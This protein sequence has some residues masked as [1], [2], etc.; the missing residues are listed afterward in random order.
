LIRFIHFLLI[1]SILSPADINC[2]QAKII[3]KHRVKKGIALQEYPGS[4]D[5][6][7]KNSLFKVNVTHL[8]GG[9]NAILRKTLL[10]FNYGTSF[11]LFLIALQDVTKLC[12]IPPLDLGA[13]FDSD[14]DHQSTTGGVQSSI[15]NRER[16]SEGSNQSSQYVKTPLDSPTLLAQGSYNP[17]AAANVTRPR[18]P[19]AK[20]YSLDDGPW[21]YRLGEKNQVQRGVYMELVDHSSYVTM[22]DTIRERNRKNDDDSECFAIL[23]HVSTKWNLSPFPSFCFASRETLMTS[24]FG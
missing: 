24:G 6:N 17:G 7:I 13:S 22:V 21:I 16:S 3:A 20:G 11:S 15:R 18:S 12:V 19:A 23:I 4:S 8:V 14:R 10:Y 9:Q 5:E 2:L 1:C